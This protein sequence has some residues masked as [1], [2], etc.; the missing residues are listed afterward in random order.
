MQGWGEAHVPP[1]R[2]DSCQSRTVSQAR[3]GSNHQE[4]PRT[5]ERGDR[6]REGGGGLVQSVG[7]SVGQGAR[8][9]QP[10]TYK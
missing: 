7:N 3:P 6:H 2:L 4:T 8:F 1:W 5:E 10:K 9:L